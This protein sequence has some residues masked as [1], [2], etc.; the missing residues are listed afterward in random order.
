MAFDDT[1]RRDS[2]RR[3]FDAEVYPW[4][5]YDLRTQS[6]HMIWS[7]NNSFVCTCCESVR[8]FLISHFQ[9]D[10]LEDLTTFSVESGSGVF[11]VDVTE[12]VRTIQWYTPV[13]RYIDL[14]DVIV[15]LHQKI[16]CNIWCT[17]IRTPLRES[18]L[19]ATRAD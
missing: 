18:C 14:E 4:D 2:W 16:M 13:I 9:M 15:Y 11:Y 8:E 5:Q 19:G 12:D 7:N 1:S 10:D 6:I 17:R 3:D